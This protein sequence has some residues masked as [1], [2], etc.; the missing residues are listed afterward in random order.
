MFTSPNVRL[1]EFKNVGES[2]VKVAKK[3]IKAKA[4]AAAADAALGAGQNITVIYREKQTREAVNIFDAKAFIDAIED[5]EPVVT[6]YTTDWTKANIYETASQPDL[7]WK[8]YRLAFSESAVAPGEDIVAKISRKDD[9]I[10][11]YAKLYIPKGVNMKYKVAAKY[12][13]DADK[14]AVQLYYGR[15]DNSNNKIYMYN[16]PVIDDYY[17]IDATDVDQAF[18]LRTNSNLEPATE[19]VAEPVTA[20]E[21]A[22]YSLND[23]D[24]YYFN[25]DLAVQNQLRFATA[26]I[27]NQELKNNEEF[28]DRD[29]YYMANPKLHGFGFTKFDKNAK[30]PVG[31]DKAGGYKSMAKNSLYIVGKKNVS[32]AAELEIVFE[33]DDN[34]D[35]NLTGI[36]NVKNAELNN[37]AIYNLQGV[38]VNNAQKGIFIKNGKKFVIK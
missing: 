36:E 35:P 29:V 37:D 32:G 14:N 20:E 25:A 1:I 30:Y 7:N 2:G 16:L 4:F 10:Y 15:I 23:A 28:V 33:G 9:Q 38:R 17:W 19:I 22:I 13:K 31:H 26:E 27:A 24:H 21:D 11:G 6:L 8:V 3:A 34:F 5:D 12:D 18:V